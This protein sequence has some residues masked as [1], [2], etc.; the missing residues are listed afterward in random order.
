MSP[1][2]SVVSQPTYELGQIACQHLLNL[3]S[4]QR[5]QGSVRLPT[6]FVHRQ[7]TGPLPAGQE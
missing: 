5:L 7:S 1:A 3:I 6:R 4:G 2:L